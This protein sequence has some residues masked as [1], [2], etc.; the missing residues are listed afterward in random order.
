MPLR[1]GFDAGCCTGSAD[2]RRDG[3]S[4]GFMVLLRQFGEPGFQPVTR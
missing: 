1:V 2:E 3:T 4:D